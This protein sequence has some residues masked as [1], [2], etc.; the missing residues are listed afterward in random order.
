MDIHFAGIHRIIFAPIFIII[1]LI[2]LRNC[3]KIL[4]SITLI[5]HKATQSSVFPYFSS[6]KQII[7][8]ILLLGSLFFLLIAWIQPQWGKHDETVIQ[9]GRDLLIMLDVSRSMLAEDISPT[10]LDF[11]KLKIR[12]LL[13]QLPVDRVGLIL[14]SGTAFLQCPLTADRAAFLLFLDQVDVHSIPSGTTA[15]DAALNK[16]I[17]IFEASEERKNKLSLLITDGED[18]STTLSS[19]RKKAEELGMTLF[20]LGVGSKEGAPVPKFD[21][22]GKRIGHETESSGEIILTKLNEPLLQE[23][24]K[25]LN[26]TYLSASYDDNDINQLANLVKG[27]EKERF[28]DKKVSLYEEQYHWFLGVAWLLLA[29]EW[30]L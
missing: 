14:F 10:R 12:N 2:A 11:A 5:T 15:I 19:V 8:T 29:L 17:E 30:I 24:C 18:F 23:T 13:E 27:F 16:G 26:G 3:F 21:L 25:Q 4:R 28:K 1:G 22:E 9:E 7:K 6:R 20:I